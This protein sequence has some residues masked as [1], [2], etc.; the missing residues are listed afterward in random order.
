VIKDHPVIDLFSFEST[1]PQH[2]LP[3]LQQYLQK[4]IDESIGTTKVRIISFC[5]FA[6]EKAI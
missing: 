6:R 3:L 1:L 5:V 4:Q 2:H